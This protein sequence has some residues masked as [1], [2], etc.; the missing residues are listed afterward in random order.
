MTY[1]HT[2]D[3]LEAASIETLKLLRDDVARSDHE[4][5][6]KMVLDIDMM[7]RERGGVPPGEP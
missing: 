5:W 1:E 4:D 3:V 2:D 7:I 6:E